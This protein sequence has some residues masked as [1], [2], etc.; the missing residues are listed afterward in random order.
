VKGFS[1]KDIGNLTK[2]WMVSGLPPAKRMEADGLGAEIDLAPD[3][4]MGPEGI[5]LECAAEEFTVPVAEV[6]P[7]EHHDAVGLSRQIRCHAVGN[8]R[9]VTVCYHA[10]KGRA[11]DQAAP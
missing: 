8:G 1:R 4:A 7:N 9:E 5:R 11:R 2:E 3:Q 10:H 6:T